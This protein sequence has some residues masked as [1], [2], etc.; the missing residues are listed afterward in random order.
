MNTRAKPRTSRVIEWFRETWAELN[1]L[2]RR[3][4]ELQMQ[5]P[6]LRITLEA[7]EREQLER[8]Y[9]LP[10]RDPDHGLE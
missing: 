10:A 4:I 6:S 5:A 7:W 9:A 3:S 2:Q 1:Y 8:T